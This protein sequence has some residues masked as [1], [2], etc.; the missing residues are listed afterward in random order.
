MTPPPPPPTNARCCRC[1]P[2]FAAPARPLPRAFAGAPRSLV[3]KARHASTPFRCIVQ[4]SRLKRFSVEA[5]VRPSGAQDSSSASPKWIPQRRPGPPP[6]P[7]PPR[8]RRRQEEAWRPPRPPRSLRRES[9]SR[10]RRRP[11]RPTTVS[12]KYEIGCFLLL[13]VVRQVL[14]V[15]PRGRKLRH[16]SLYFAI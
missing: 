6:P 15:K 14:N 7:R 12:C 4:G 8:V 5:R 10:R 2:A 3:P 1:C 16:F 9:S 13:Q 11:R